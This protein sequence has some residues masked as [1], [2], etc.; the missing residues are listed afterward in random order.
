[1][2]RV[3]TTK[4]RVLCC[5]HLPGGGVFSWRDSWLVMGCYR[6]CGWILFLSIR[7]EGN[8]DGVLVSS[9]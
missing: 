4:G 3:N 6:V 2:G 8:A 9:C 1:M 5:V 7:V